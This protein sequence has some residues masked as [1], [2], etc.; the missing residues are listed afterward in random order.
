MRRILTKC[1]GLGC[2]RYVGEVGY[3]RRYGSSD[4]RKLCDQV[5]FLNIYSYF[6]DKLRI[7]K[8]AEHVEFIG[9]TFM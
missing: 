7:I 9:N 3:K 2:V 5:A 8:W 6:Y 4:W 1:N